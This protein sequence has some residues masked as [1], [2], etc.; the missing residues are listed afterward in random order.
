MCSSLLTY[1]DC[2]KLIEALEECHR[3]GMTDRIFGACNNQK[4]ALVKCLRKDRYARQK[5]HMQESVKRSKEMK[6][7]WKKMDEEEYGPGGYLREVEQKKKEA[8]N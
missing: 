8:T 1:L 6:E 2:G 4:D 7:K 3:L 5:E